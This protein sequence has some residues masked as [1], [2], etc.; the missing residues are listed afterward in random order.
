MEGGWVD[1]RDAAVQ[2]SEMACSRGVAAAIVHRAGLRDIE[3]LAVGLCFDPD[4]RSQRA[5]QRAVN[6]RPGQLFL[7]TFD[8]LESGVRLVR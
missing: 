7:E 4:R 3:R 6:R 1:D 2:R 5:M 8:P